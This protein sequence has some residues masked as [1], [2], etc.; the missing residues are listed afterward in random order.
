MKLLHKICITSCVL[1]VFI[2]N[3]G[4]SNNI[5]CL[6][7]IIKDGS[8]FYTELAGLIGTN[9]LDQSFV[10]ARKD[11]LFK[12]FGKQIKEKCYSSGKINDLNDIAEAGAIS[13]RFVFNDKKYKINI[14]TFKLFNHVPLNSIETGILIV[15]KKFSNYTPGDEIPLDK[16]P[17][18][19]YVVTKDCS[20]HVIKGNWEINDDLEK[21]PISIAARQTNS[22]TSQY[23]MYFVDFPTKHNCRAFPGLL[24]E[25][26]G[27]REEGLYSQN[28]YKTAREKFK[29]FSEEVSK[30]GNA[31]RGKYAYI[32]DL[33]DANKTD[34]SETWNMFW[35]RLIKPT[36]EKLKVL[37]DAESL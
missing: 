29:T 9:K 24:L 3:A 23:P 30:Q 35:K 34:A 7:D 32:V 6:D 17:A 33:S 4:M 16:I 8:S 19:D 15:D 31:C 11:S 18:G 14:D 36:P 22:I 25:K 1:S 21:S 37:S 26:K 2:I 27:Y 10:T 13:I 28:N 20:P 5:S 12:L